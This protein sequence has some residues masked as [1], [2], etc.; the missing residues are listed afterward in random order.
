MANE[1]VDEVLRIGVKRPEPAKPGFMIDMIEDMPDFHVGKQALRSRGYG[2]ACGL[3]FLKFF[4]FLPESFDSPRRIHQF[5]LA[6]IKGVAIPTYFNPNV[7]FGGAGL[8]LV[9][10]G[11][12]DDCFGILWMN[13]R[14][15]VD[16]SPCF[17]QLVLFVIRENRPKKIRNR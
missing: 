8:Y 4:V 11:A 12:F 7:L 2:S 14:F 13:I 16:V 3:R 9:A 6:G 15:H 1:S 17:F 5:L 10:A